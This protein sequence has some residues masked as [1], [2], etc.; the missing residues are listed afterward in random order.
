MIQYS[1]KHF[2]NEIIY[3][4][5]NFTCLSNITFHISILNTS[6]QTFYCF[7]ITPQGSCCFLS[8]TSSLCTE[9]PPSHVVAGNQH[10][11]LMI[12]T[13]SEK[14]PFIFPPLLPFQ[15]GLQYAIM[16]L[17][18]SIIHHLP[19]TTEHRELAGVHIIGWLYGFGKKYA[20][21]N[22][23]YSDQGIEIPFLI[24]WQNNKTFVWA[25]FDWWS[26]RASRSLILKN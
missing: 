20:N 24:N 10:I 18:Q 8:S 19:W 5:Q 6:Y 26:S 9:C 7:L 25:V 13:T 17:L 16:S 23:P 4:P 21:C 15:V 2:Y 14:L 3:E 22:I 12:S 1:R 11:L